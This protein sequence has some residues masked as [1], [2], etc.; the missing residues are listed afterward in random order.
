MDDPDFKKRAE[1]HWEYVKGILETH[2][3]P[4]KEIKDIGY[5]YTTALMHGYKHGVSDAEKWTKLGK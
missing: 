3:V 2:D 1:Q 5:H 4:D